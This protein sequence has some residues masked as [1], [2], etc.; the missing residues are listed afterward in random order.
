MVCTE[1]HTEAGVAAAN[2][3]GSL[4]HGASGLVEGG[5]QHTSSKHKRQFGVEMAVVKVTRRV[6][7]KAECGGKSQAQ[8]DAASWCLNDAKGLGR[9]RAGEEG[10]RGREG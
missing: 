3:T 5:G 9:Q 2:G 7:R 10:F 4:A 8:G 6:V 1:G